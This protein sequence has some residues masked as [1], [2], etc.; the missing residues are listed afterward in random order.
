ME[1]KNISTPGPES[2]AST[3]HLDSAALTP[4]CPD[5][6][7]PSPP[8]PVF[9]SLESPPTSTPPSD[10]YF[11]T[12]IYKDLPYEN[13]S[14]A[15]YPLTSMQEADDLTSTS[16]STSEAICQA[17]S[18]LDFIVSYQ[19]GT[20]GALPESVLHPTASLLQSYIE[21]GIPDSTGPPW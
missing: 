4:P 9:A 1:G 18:L 12:W 3:S 20:L 10:I 8:C 7:T 13:L 5:I 2:H 19:R 21:E 17:P 11:G 6:L 15:S 16:K 14:K